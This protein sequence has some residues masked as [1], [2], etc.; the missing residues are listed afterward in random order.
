MKAYLNSRLYLICFVQTLFYNKKRENLVYFSVFDL[1]SVE[2]THDYL[3]LE[4]QP[5]ALFT[6]FVQAGVEPQILYKMRNKPII[7]GYQIHC[8]LGATTGKQLFQAVI[9][10]LS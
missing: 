2:M 10:H 4:I 7:L 5:P 3:C 1:N 6:S 8:N 9:G